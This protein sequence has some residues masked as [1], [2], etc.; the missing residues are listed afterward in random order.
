MNAEPF[1]P[2]RLTLPALA[3]AVQRCGLSALCD[4]TK[5]YSGRATIGAGHA[6]R[7]TAGRP[8][9]PGRQTV[10][11]TSRTAPR[12]RARRSGYRSEGDLRHKRRQA[13]QVE[14]ARPAPDPRQAVL[15]EQLACRPWLDAELAVVK[16]EVLILLGATAAQALLG[17]SFRVTRDRGRVPHSDLAKTVIATIH[18]ARSSD[19]ATATK[20]SA[21]RRR[22]RPRRRLRQRTAGFRPTWVAA[23]APRSG[24]TL[25]GRG[26]PGGSRSG[27]SRPAPS[28]GFEDRLG[29]RPAR[30]A[31]D[32]HLDGDALRDRVEVGRPG[33]LLV[34]RA[35]E[36]AVPPEPEDR[37][38][39]LVLALRPADPDLPVPRPFAAAVAVLPHRLLVRLGETSASPADRR[40]RPPSA[41]RG[42]GDRDRLL[43]ER[44]E[45]RVV[46]RVVLAAVRLLAALPEQ[47]DHLDRLLEHLDPLVGRGPAVAER[48]ARSGSRPCRARA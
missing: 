31:L 1:L 19:P 40:A 8:G 24:R 23:P 33:Q 10:R 6:R 47:A 46:D 25:P 16:P 9:G 27:R 17:R 5:R 44:V 37:L 4:A 35:A 26:R 11:G 29:I 34:D 15:V 13:L 22:S 20:C 3:E 36:A 43:G 7:R 39:R 14:S 18:P 2:N 41:R 48:R 28:V 32:R 42:D 30:H 12:P 21:P 45:L 38:L